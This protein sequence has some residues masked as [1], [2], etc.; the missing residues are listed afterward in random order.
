MWDRPYIPQLTAGTVAPQTFATFAGK[1]NLG[2]EIR[3]LSRDASDGACS[4]IWEVP[5]GWN[6]HGGFRLA[7]DEQLFVLDGDFKKGDNVYTAGCY[8]Y[9]KPGYVHEPMSS[10]S[11]ARLVAFWNSALTDIGSQNDLTCPIGN[12]SLFTDTNEDE[13]V[14]TPIDGPPDGIVVNMLNQV[15]ETGGMTMLISIPPGW[16]EPRAEH[17]DCYEESYKVSG[18]IWMIENGI[19]QTVVG[20]DYFYRL[21]KIKHGPMKTEQGTTSLIRFSAT[22][23]NHYGPVEDQSP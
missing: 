4:C 12:G 1:F 9:R 8:G 7:G 22:L 6:H 5:P 2:G 21:P 15:E 11:G 16:Q 14:P 19:E 17:H 3:L 10:E 13:R 18:D 20:G 23:V